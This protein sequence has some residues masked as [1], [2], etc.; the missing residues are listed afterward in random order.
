[1]TSNLEVHF[2]SKS[3]EWSTPDSL[4]NKYNSIFNFNL[5]SAATPENTK[6]SNYYTKEN[7]GLSKD[8]EGYVWCNPPYS[9][10]S[11]WIKKG[12]E[13]HLKH[14]STIVMLIPARPDTK[15]WINYIVDKASIHFIIG[16]LKFSNSSNSAPFPS[17]VII[18]SNQPKEIK[19]VTSK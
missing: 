16:R 5:D 14:K 13:E 19:W 3:D 15:A 9:K 6:C 4:F 7:N 18:Y 1:M 8:W 2:S 12:Y 10:I 11:D 17:A